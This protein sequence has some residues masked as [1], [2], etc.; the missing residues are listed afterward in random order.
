M[1]DSWAAYRLQATLD[2]QQERVLHDTEEAILDR[3]WETT[4]E[5]VREHYSAGANLPVWALGSCLLFACSNV[6]EGESSENAEFIAVVVLLLSKGADVEFRD[7]FG[8]TPL[9]WSSKHGHATVVRILL[10]SGSGLNVT[11]D[12][13]WTA[14]MVASRKGRD[15][16]VELLLEKGASID[17]ENENGDTALMLAWEYGHVGAVILLLVAYLRLRAS[18][19]G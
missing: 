5:L 9:L 2:Y 12:R 15:T 1:A 13:G 17:E 3:N 10:N 8:W 11:N 7:H 18:S 16:V 14:L 4:R 19:T 6:E